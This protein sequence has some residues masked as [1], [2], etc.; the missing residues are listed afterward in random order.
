MTLRFRIPPTAF[1]LCAAVVLPITAVAADLRGF[2]APGPMGVILF[3]PCSGKAMS[4]RLLQVEDETPDSALTAG[5][6]D[7]RK[8]MLEAGRPLYVEFR[9][10]TVG[11]VAKARR[12]Q[13]ASGTITSCADAASDIP[14]AAPLWATGEDPSWRLVA[15]AT[16]VRLERPG[17]PPVRFPAPVFAAATAKSTKSPRI[18]DAWSVQDGGSIRV[19]ITEQMCSDGRSETAFGASV[20]VRYGSRSYQGCAARY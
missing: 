11:L 7:V 12:F 15:G 2:A 10:D 19:E 13:R 8:I 9:G 18:V 4:N 17:L 14:A 20:S 5:I 1:A 16:D 6:D 3:Q